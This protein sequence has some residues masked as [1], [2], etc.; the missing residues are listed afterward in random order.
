MANTNSKRML[1]ITAWIRNGAHYRL[2]VKDGR[3]IRIQHHDSFCEESIYPNDSNF[4]WKFETAVY[5][6]FEKEEVISLKKLYDVLEEDN[7]KIKVKHYINELIEKYEK[8][9]AIL[10]S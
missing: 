3:I 6:L 10:K 2:Y 1:E 9:L 4:D 7:L 8:S 5:Y